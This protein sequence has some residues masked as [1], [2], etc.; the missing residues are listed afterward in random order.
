MISVVG[1]GA[2]STEV[3]VSVWHPVPVY[4]VCLVSSGVLLVVALATAWRRNRHLV[5]A[6][7]VDERDR[8]FRTPVHAAG[9]FMGLA[10]LQLTGFLLA[11]GRETWAGPLGGLLF[12]GVLAGMWRAFWCGTGITLRPGGIEAGKSAGAL[13]IPWEALA[14]QQ[15]DRSSP[16]SWQVELAYA[17]PELVTSTGWTPMRDKVEFEGVGPD[18]VAEAVAL[19]AAE[20]GRR[21]A[22]GTVAELNRLQEGMP[23]QRRRIRESETPVPIRTTVRRLVAGSVLLAGSAFAY[24]RGWFV[25]SIPIGSV[26]A[27]QFY[28]AV[29][30]WWAHRRRGIRE[31]PFLTD[32]S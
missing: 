21:N 25:V 6:F 8:S 29:A 32:R 10:G 1:L 15:P 19:Y 24:G 13:V 17:R 14:A 18:F 5:A 11:A 12:G 28:R 7:V 22:I 16:T 2:T 30:G 27:N 3:A 23:A 26:A 9:L 20:P 4:V 31:T